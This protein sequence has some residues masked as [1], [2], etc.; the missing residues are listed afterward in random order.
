MRRRDALKAAGIG[1]L[2][3]LGLG[4]SAL[5][6]PV[7]HGFPDWNRSVAA[8]DIQIFNNLALNLTGLTQTD[9]FFVGHM[10][11][12]YIRANSTSSVN[13]G[14]SWFADKAATI[15]LFGDVITTTTG[16]EAIQS[17]PVRGPYVRFTLERGA[18]PGTI[19]FQALMTPVP[20]N[21]YSGTDGENTLISVDGTNVG[22]G[23]TSNFNATNTRG[24]W[25]Y[26]HAHLET[27]AAFRIRL[28]AIDFT[29][30]AHLIDIVPA[31][32]NQEGKMLFIPALPMRMQVF[33][34]DAVAR[35][36]F[37]TLVHH[38]FYP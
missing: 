11:Y 31:S 15:S 13:V 8:S 20:F 33:N 4:V 21:A 30:V 14:V 22:A 36:F 38:P 29:G 10:P 23:V 7:S 28:Q 19:G 9:V 32:V 26:W 18:Y 2:A 37:G 25:A 17:V 1:V 16:G 27:A 6:S 34:A 12:M 5:T 24:G 3:L 35:T